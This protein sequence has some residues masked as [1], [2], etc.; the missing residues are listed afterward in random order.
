MLDNWPYLGHGGESGFDASSS[1]TTMNAKSATSSQLP[2]IKKGIIMYFN[3]NNEQITFLNSKVVSGFPDLG[4]QEEIFVGEV[5][6]SSGD[7][8]FHTGIWDPRVALSEE[9]V[10]TDNVDF[11]II[12]PFFD[13]LKFFNM[14]KDGVL[15]ISI[16]LTETLQ[17][18]C[19]ENDYQG[20]ECQSLD[21]DDDGLRD[22][23]DNCPNT[24]N[25]DQVDFDGDGE[26]DVCDAD[27]DGDSAPNEDDECA[28]TPVGEIVDPETGCSIAQL[29]PCEG[30]RGTLQSWKNHSKYVSCTAKS[31]ESFVEK[32]LIT[33]EEKDQIVSSAAQ[34]SCGDKK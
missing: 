17:T 33:E 19:T 22:Y 28:F 16:D 29:C 32:G 23:E 27:V 21:L 25:P 15:Q 10:F 12:I 3:I 5:F 2:I 30:P 6:S 24:P 8:I 20:R 4:L 14:R 11:H 1:S 7:L 9:V 26:G 18:H 34:S 31:S 13:N